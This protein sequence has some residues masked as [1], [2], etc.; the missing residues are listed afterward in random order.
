MLLNPFWIWQPE[1][2]TQFG[3]EQRGVNAAQSHGEGVGWGGGDVVF[4]LLTLAARVMP[5]GC[6]RRPFKP[7]QQAQRG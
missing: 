6:V 4:S 5:G 3:M 1:Q 7:P 2:R